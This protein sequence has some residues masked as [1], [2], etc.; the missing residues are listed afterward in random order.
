MKLMSTTARCKPI[1]PH[2]RWWAFPVLVAWVSLGAFPRQAAALTI[3]T[4]YTRF[5]ESP[6]IR[7]IRQYFG[8][9]LTGQR[10]RTVVAS[11]PDSPAGQYFI[12][13]LKGPRPAPPAAA[14]IT[15]YATDAMAPRTRQWPLADARLENWLYLGLTGPDWPDPKVQPLAWHIEL[16]D[17][18]GATLA[19]WKSFL[20]EMP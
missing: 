3:E 9:S 7:P 13:R 8:A 12:L 19:E 5:Y 14:R 2:A 1:V 18:A 17:A 4:A 16:L 10:Y 6:E 20:W 15:W 11:Q